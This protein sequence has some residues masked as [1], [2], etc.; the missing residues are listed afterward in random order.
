MDFGDY[1][2]NLTEFFRLLTLMLQNKRSVNAKLK[3]MLVVDIA[4]FGV[5]LCLN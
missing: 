5:L 3:N 4:N 1:H 2:C